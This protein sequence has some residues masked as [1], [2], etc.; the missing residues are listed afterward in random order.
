M[1]SPGEDG[2]EKAQCPLKM[3]V[4]TLQLFTTSISYFCIVAIKYQVQGT[5]AHC[6]R[7]PESM[8]VGQKWR[9]E[10][11]VH[12]LNIKQEADMKQDWL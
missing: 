7:K 5:W 10:A 1:I 9:Q 2:Q 8:V 12:I 4:C 3:R 11:E 6:S